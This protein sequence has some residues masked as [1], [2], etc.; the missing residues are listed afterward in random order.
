MIGFK[1][2]FDLSEVN[3][4]RERLLTDDFE[5]ETRFDFILLLEDDVDITDMLTLSV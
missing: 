4:S 2:A 3:D 5:I 1:V